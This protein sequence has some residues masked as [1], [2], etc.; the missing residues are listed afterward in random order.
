MEL[1]KQQV[2]LSHKIISKLNSLVGLSFD[3]QEEVE[4]QLSV[5][6]SSEVTIEFIEIYTEM[7]E[8][9]IYK[10]YTLFEGIDILIFIGDNGKDHDIVGIKCGPQ[11]TYLNEAYKNILK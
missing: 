2:H 9:P 3:S 5:S 1:N 11:C 4:M 7:E 6:L 8:G 10:Y